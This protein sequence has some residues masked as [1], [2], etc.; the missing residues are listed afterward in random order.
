M[1]RKN[2]NN[3]LIG[4]YEKALPDDL[5]LE[6]KLSMIGRAGYSFMEISIDSSKERLERLKWDNL[7]I[8]KFRDLIQDKDK[9]VLV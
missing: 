6:D 7:K 5:S 1:D 4:L 2:N 8:K 3:H 9:Y